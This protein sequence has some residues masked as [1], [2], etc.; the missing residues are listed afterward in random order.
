MRVAIFGLGY[1]GR[2]LAQLW[3]ERYRLSLYSRSSSLDGSAQLDVGQSGEVL[4]LAA[5]GLMHW[6]AAIVTLPAHHACP[7]FW[8]L[9]FDACPHVLVYGTTGIYARHD[10][11]REELDEDSPVDPEHPRATIETQLQARGAT[12]LRLA[13]IYGPGRNPRDWLARGLVGA[14]NRQVNFIHLNDIAAVTGMMLERRPPDRLYNVADGQPHSWRQI[15]DL[16]HKSGLLETI[17]P[18]KNAKFDSVIAIGRI[19]RAYP[20]LR[21]RDFWL[22][23]DELCA[24]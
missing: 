7:E 2:H 17:A 10:R 16:L 14:D 12:V 13:G 21:F 1:T 3:Q 11:Y 5:R 23:L 19:L 18:P 24:T 22:M 8:D 20:G 4:R 15:A 9:L 6:D